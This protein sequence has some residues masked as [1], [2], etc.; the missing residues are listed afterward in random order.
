MGQVTWQ[1]TGVVRC[2]GGGDG[3]DDGGSDGCC[4]CCD[5]NGG[6]TF[7]GGAEVMSG[8]ETAVMVLFQCWE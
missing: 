4:C 7:G 2:S 5:D 8:I 1:V 6:D 3:R